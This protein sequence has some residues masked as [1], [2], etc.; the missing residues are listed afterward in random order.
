MSRVQARGVSLI[1]ALVALAVMA[2]GILGMVGIQ[3][4]LRVNGDVSK[5]RS[6]AVRIAQQRIEQARSFSVLNTTQNQTAY[7]DIVSAGPTSIS[8]NA[9]NT[10]FNLQTTVADA[11]TGNAKNVQVAVTWADRTVDS[12][13][14][15]QSVGLTTVITGIAPALAGSLAAP[16]NSSVVRLPSGRNLAIPP[17]AIDQ[18]SGTSI[19]TPPGA[20]GGL[21][22]VFNNA[23]GMITSVCTT[24]DHRVTCSSANSFL[25]SGYV[26][27]STRQTPDGENPDS[28]PIPLRVSVTITAPAGS[29]RTNDS[30]IC[31]EEI[32]NG[33]RYLAY[34]CAI[35]IRPADPQKWSGTSLLVLSGYDLAHDANDDNINHYRV[36][37]YTPTTPSSKNVDHPAAYVDVN[38]PLTN[39]NFL[40]ISAGNDNGNG[41]GH[42]TYSCPVDDTS[43]PVDT[44]TVQYQP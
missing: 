25:L 32:P 6:E 15:N 19:F 20:S 42:T 5:Q 10:V 34:Y 41:N 16:I 1:E 44:N 29:T 35:P 21:S 2:F 23:T 39:Q 18:G 31:Y 4:T 9:Y 33:A 30:S 27:Y 43:T 12:S 22:W 17:G 28:T 8:N 13:T 40:V 36:C 7:Q 14:P 24:S 38:G 37:R 26:R 11:A 3:A